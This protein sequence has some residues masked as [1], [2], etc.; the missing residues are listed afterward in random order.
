MSIP[1]PQPQ[2]LPLEFEA[3]GVHNHPV[4][5]RLFN[6]EFRFARFNPLEP[7][8]IGL[9]DKTLRAAITARKEPLPNQPLTYIL[10]ECTAEEATEWVRQQTTSNSTF[11]HTIENAAAVTAWLFAERSQQNRQW[12]HGV[13][14]EVAGSGV[15]ITG[16]SGIG[17]SELALEL[18][19]RGHRLI[20]DD[21]PYFIRGHQGIEGHCPDNI[22]DLLEVRGLGII[23]VRSLFGDNALKPHK[24]L[25]LLIE[26]YAADHKNIHAD[27]RL[28][29]ERGQ[30][31]ICQEMIPL[32]R[33]P[34]A[35]GRNIAVFVETVVRQHNL[36]RTGNDSTSPGRI[37]I[38]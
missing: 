29:G 13:F 35:P 5:E 27:D 31:M 36:E 4:Y 12:Q 14:M 22:K 37:P 9:L 25:R 24:N 34:V 1:M 32:F 3:T 19:S 33:L 6:P 8:P 16:A 30:I 10:T 11:L 20:A 15:L 17:K 23:N 2:I 26:L 7:Q 28:R 18:L 38:A 21:A